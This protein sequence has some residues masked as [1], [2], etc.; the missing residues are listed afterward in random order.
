[1]NNGSCRVRVVVP[2]PLV[3]LVGKSTLTYPL[4]TKDENEA[5]SRSTKKI[6]EF[7]EIISEATDYKSKDNSTATNIKNLRW[8]YIDDDPF[9]NYTRRGQPPSVFLIPVFLKNGELEGYRSPKPGDP[10]RPIVAMVRLWADSRSRR[11]TRKTWA[12]VIRKITRLADFIGDFNPFTISADDL[13]GYPAALFA[14]GLKPSTVDDHL[15]YVRAVFEAMKQADLIDVNPAAHLR[16]RLSSM[17]PTRIK[18]RRKP[19]SPITHGIWR[20]ISGPSGSQ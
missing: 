15:V 9:F 12:D 11:I 18:A 7:K 10:P 19:L 16:P 8:Y 13:A 1:M 20:K 4:G 2:P 17:V 5:I 6:A 3:S 14:E